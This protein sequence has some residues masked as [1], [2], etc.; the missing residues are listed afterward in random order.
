M[1]ILLHLGLN[2]LKGSIRRVYSSVA[3]AIV[4]TLVI[5]L[6]LGFMLMFLNSDIPLSGRVPY[7]MIIPVY[8]SFAF[9]IV[10]P[11]FLSKH[12][13]LLTENDA[14]V[15][16]T[17]P[18]SRKQVIAYGLMANLT[19]A[20]V[21]TFVLYAYLGSMII[22]ISTAH[23]LDWLY[24]LITSCLL[25]MTCY[26]FLD[27]LY[28]RFMVHP[29]RK[30][31]RSLIVIIILAFA[32]S[33]F[34]YYYFTLADQSAKHLLSA[35]V[36]SD[37]FN[38]IPVFGWIRYS[39]LAF[40]DGEVLGALLSLFGIIG[41][42]LA[43]IG[44][45]INTKE[46]DVEVLMSDS[47][48]ISRI[49]DRQRTN[50]I[51][52]NLKAT[53][54]KR[55]SFRKGAFAISSRLLLELRKTK[56]FITVQEL[57]FIVVYLVISIMDGFSFVFY[58]RYILII[59]F[60]ITSSANYN[61]ELKRHYLYLIP[62][63]PLKKLIALLLP[64]IL[65]LVI[66]VTV[67]LIFGII[68]KPTT[69]EFFLSYL[70]VFACSL[71][72]VS[73]NIWSYRILKQGKNDLASNFIKMFIILVAMIPSLILGFIFNLMS[74]ANIFSLV[75]ALVNLIVSCILIYASKGV[76]TGADLINN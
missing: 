62:D 41:L 45:T 74:D 47:E 58:S 21:F 24:L 51:Y 31:I 73:A 22:G 30:L 5:L 42:N 15:L 27:M 38:L 29:H 66:V 6:L 32:L 59:M 39:L 18:F 25:F 20:L 71:L 2:R 61:D 23:G 72:F 35:F 4:S 52:A 60:M 64:T 40:H 69:T 17:G 56:S 46:L 16:L 57:I 68:L 50:N 67:T 76:V 33:I 14:N 12:A 49:K 48:E 28:I 11:A 8:L 26:N 55:V 7:Q 37:L 36:E 1:G 70:E 53:E 44:Y 65:K 10:S 13:A 75:S 43:I 54:V 63:K 9:I 34:G 19:N 3:S